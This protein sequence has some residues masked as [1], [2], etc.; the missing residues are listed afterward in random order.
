MYKRKISLFILTL[1]L[2]SCSST[3]YSL[4]LG[5][6]SGALVGAG[7]G[8]AINKK[9][10]AGYGA[11]IGAL[12]GGVTSY[13]IDKEVRKREK[14]IR[15][16]TIFNLEKYNVLGMPPE[17]DYNHLKDYVW[18]IDEKYYEAQ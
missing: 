5:I 4:G 2:I 18:D 6:G 3:K 14:E 15:R 17:K 1:F 9:N 11:A 8:M 12:I 13:F 16:K 7:T 10:S